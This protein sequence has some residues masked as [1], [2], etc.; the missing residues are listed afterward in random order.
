M[1]IKNSNFSFN[2]FERSIHHLKSQDSK[3]FRFCV[4]FENQIVIVEKHTFTKLVEKLRI[5]QACHRRAFLLQFVIC[6][7]LASSVNNYFCAIV[8]SNAENSDVK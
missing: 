4:C 1:L 8:V 2:F 3:V 5:A 6:A 7:F